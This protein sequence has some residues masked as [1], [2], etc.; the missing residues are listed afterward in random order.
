MATA[1]S[2]RWTSASEGATS[3]A[4]VGSTSWLDTLITSRRTLLV[5]HATGAH[6]GMLASSAQ[7]SEEEP[8]MTQFRGR[9]LHD[10]KTPPRRQDSELFAVCSP[11]AVITTAPPGALY[12]SLVSTLHCSVHLGLRGLSSS[13]SGSPACSR[14]HVAAQTSSTAGMKASKAVE[15]ATLEAAGSRTRGGGGAVSG[16]ASPLGV[17]SRPVPPGTARGGAGADT[18]HCQ[19]GETGGLRVPARSPGSRGDN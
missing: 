5:L 13:A 8:A 18:G 1:A 6:A 4:V 17:P 7:R 15:S 3:A 10:S 2:G 12:S 19:G 9:T 16:P 14:A 11:D